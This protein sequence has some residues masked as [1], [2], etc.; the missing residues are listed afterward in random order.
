M[1][2]ENPLWLP[3]APDAE[4]V[5]QALELLMTNVRRQLLMYGGLGRRD[6]RAVLKATDEDLSISIEETV[7]EDGLALALDA[8]IEVSFRCKTRNAHGKREHWR[9][10]MPIEE[11]FVAESLNQM[12]G[13]REEEL[14]AT[15]AAELVHVFTDGLED[16]S[17]DLR[18]PSIYA[19]SGH[20]DAD[21]IEE[22]AQKREIRI[23]QDLHTLYDRI[24]RGQL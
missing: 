15:L 13:K 12:E 23:V 22:I 1:K 19:G 9:Y 14:R 24:C 2:L 3:P 6:H 10:T 8:D 11:T 5:S 16:L 20:F 7:E 17:A 4:R 18:N 21:D